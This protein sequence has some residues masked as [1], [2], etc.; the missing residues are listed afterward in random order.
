MGSLK[1]L[2]K[3]GFSRIL[4]IPMLVDRNGFFGNWSGSQTFLLGV[5]S[6]VWS[7]VGLRSWWRRIAVVMPP[8]GTMAEY[9]YIRNHT[10]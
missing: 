8:K 5:R 4:K 6:S 9:V 3:M 2:L 10:L 7:I 1:R